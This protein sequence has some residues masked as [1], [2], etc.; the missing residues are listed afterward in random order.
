MK[1]NILLTLL[2]GVSL[3]A[4]LPATP[5]NTAV[6]SE[7]MQSNG[8]YFVLFGSIG[9][10]Y[11]EMVMNGSTGTF[12]YNNIKRKLKFGSYNRN[13]KQLILNEY[14]LRGKYIGKFV[15]RY[16]SYSYQGVFTNTKGGKAN[17]YVYCD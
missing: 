8:I 14:D 3:S 13:T 12:Q 17:F 16:E 10:A 15:G 11:C 6:I 4:T 9:D 5:S 1:R 7:H 2:L